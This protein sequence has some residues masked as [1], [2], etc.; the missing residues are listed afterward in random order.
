M[1]YIKKQSECDKK[2]IS[3]VNQKN[4]MDL[5]KEKNEK[6]E[7]ENND[8]DCHIENIEEKKI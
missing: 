1:N 8:L 5:N 2:F 3:V 6:F 7:K 4:L